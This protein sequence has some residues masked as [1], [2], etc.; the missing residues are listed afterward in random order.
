MD[1]A[2]EDIAA[3]AQALKL[4]ELDYLGGHGSRGYERVECKNFCA[5]LFNIDGR[6]LPFTADDLLQ[7][8]KGAGLNVV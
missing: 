7:L 6:S 2:K 5:S 3:L 1:E 8:L 4:L